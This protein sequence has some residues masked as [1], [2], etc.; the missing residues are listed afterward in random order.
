VPWHTKSTAPALTSWRLLL[1]N[2]PDWLADVLGALLA[3]ARQWNWHPVGT[4]TPDEMAAYYTDVISKI[5]WRNSNMALGD[6]VLSASPVLP[7][8]CLWCDG[9]EILIASYPDLYALI[10]A[11]FGAAASGYFKLPD[12]RGQFPVIAGSRAGFTTYAVGDSGGEETHTLTA[13]EMPV[14]DHSIHTHL[15]ALAVSPGEL[16]VTTPNII[17]GSTGSAGSGSAHEN[18]PPYMALN[19]YIAVR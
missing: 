5:D 10:G 6:I 2:D 4:L 7:A 19:A 14:H 8:G 9:A 18:R 11:T 3:L 17:P 15:D 16:P 12:L 13:G 1:P